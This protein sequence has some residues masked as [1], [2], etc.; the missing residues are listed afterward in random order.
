MKIA[1]LAFLALHPHLSSALDPNT[2]KEGDVVAMRVVTDSSLCRSTRK[3]IAG[4]YGPPYKVK[5]I[6]KFD[7]M[8]EHLPDAFVEF[9]NL[10]LHP[11]W[12]EHV[13]TERCACGLANSDRAPD[14]PE[15]RHTQCPL[16]PPVCNGKG[17]ILKVFYRHKEDGRKQSEKPGGDEQ[18]VAFKLDDDS[19][20]KWE[21]VIMH[22]HFAPRTHTTKPTFG[23]MNGVDISH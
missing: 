23:R 2:L 17:A 4:N 7:G 10:N 3:Y 13:T 19:P 1:G 8:F 22:P 5:K 18:T 16:Q 9:E 6:Q 21:D 15:E 11:D 20:W 12:T 14:Y